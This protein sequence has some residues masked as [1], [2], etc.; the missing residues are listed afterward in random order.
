MSLTAAPPPLIEPI[1][2]LRVLVVD[3]DAS[4]RRSLAR[5]LGARGFLV[6]TADG[7]EAAL[8]QVGSGEE[9]DVALIDLKMP[10]MDGLE[11]LS[12]IKAKRPEVAVIMMT[13]FADVD[14]AI[15]AVKGGAYHF[16]TKPFLS[17]D[18][19]AL[20]I[21][22]A[23]EH[24]RLTSRARHLEERLEAQERFGELIGT[25]VAMQ[26]VYRLVMGVANTT[27]TVLVLGESGTGKELVARAI[28]QRS[29]RA[30]KPI[31]TVNCAA[32]PKE[33]V[34]SELFGH[35]R[36]AFTG[37]HAARAGLFESA[38][39]STI[40][41]DEVGDLPLP[42][43]VKLLRTLQEG[44]V[45]RVGSDE[46]RIVDVRVVAATN[47]D[48]SAKLASGAFRRD[49]YY[50][51]NVIA[52]HLPALRD[53]ADDTLLL[54]HHFMQKLARRM[55][56]EPKRIGASAMEAIRRYAWPGNVRELEHAIEHAFVLSQTQEIGASDL[57]FTRAGHALGEAPPPKPAT[58]AASDA[59]PVA[60]L[61]A[62]PY[63]EAKR[64]AMAA[65]DQLYVAEA[66]ARAGGNI[67]DAARRAGLDRSNFR[68]VARKKGA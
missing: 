31:V 63:A 59:L 42:A 17:N 2:P 5:I 27:S 35:V 57:P 34:E 6:S 19:V 45:K 47:V 49:L 32:I 38:H 48:L 11:L 65:F 33:L 64:C 50:R 14:T 21:A 7:G 52:I 4:L 43:Q 46:T 12:R 56:R 22:K 8:E 66:I 28:H 37:A 18:A 40:F 61:L 29:D 60:D 55:G 44:E 58:A 9:P 39:G 26:E 54:T 53:R 62:L 41:L 67:A 1:T 15:A 23:A 16:L 20:T 13:A 30:S 10:G 68:R 36:G 51:L 24:R 3:D 25:S